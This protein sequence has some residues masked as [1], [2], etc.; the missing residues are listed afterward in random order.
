M[1]SQKPR[2]A[3]NLF[4]EIPLSNRREYDTDELDP[5]NFLSP[6]YLMIDQF[7]SV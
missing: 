4:E 2:S 1:M 3:L 7:H 6:Y 5:K